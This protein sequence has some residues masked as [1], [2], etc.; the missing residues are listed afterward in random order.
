MGNTGLF[1][2][3]AAY[4]EATYGVAPALTAAKYYA[5]STDSLGL[6][7]TPKQSKGIFAGAQFDK[8]ARRVG[9]L[10]YSVTGAFNLD[11]PERGM[12]QWLYRMLGSF[13][14]SPATLTEDG[15]T[16]AYK[17]VHAPG[18]IDGHSFSLQKG[19][20]G[21]D[22]TVV[23]M[24]YTGCKVQA[25]ELSAALSDIVKLALTIEGRNELAFSHVDPLNGS[26]PS[27]A[28]YTAPAG[29]VFRWVGATMYV[30]GTPST[31]SGVTTLASPTL[32]GNISGPMSVKYNRPLDLTR[33]SPDVA[34]YRNEPYQNDVTAVTG[35]TTVEFV[36]TETYYA[37]FQADTAT[38][39][40]YQFETVGI[41]TGSDIA[42]FSVLIPNIR[43]ETAPLPISGPGIVKQAITWT[44]LDDGTNNPVQVTYVTLDAS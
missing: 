34:P 7:K 15:S 2:Q 30:G 11:L 23:P 40:E 33:Y 14:Q 19:V 6:K 44:G 27:L 32:A 3:W 13:G 16:G 22:G 4:D 42:T 43:I 21:V 24:T 9:A 18:F 28:S 35:A 17:A 36:S 1:A 37:A 39:I 5:G 12:Q 8:A 25:W 29:N 31:T 10:E 20:P 26:V 41:G 38:A